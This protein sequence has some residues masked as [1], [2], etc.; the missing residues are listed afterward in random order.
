[1]VSVLINFT[2][3]VEEVFRCRKFGHSHGWLR[4]FKPLLWIWILLGICTV[5]FLRPFAADAREAPQCSGI[6]STPQQLTIECRPGYATDFDRVIIYTPYELDPAKDWSKQ[7]DYSFATWIFDA[8][9][10]N[11]ANLIIVFARQDKEAIAQVYDDVNG[12]GMI[13]YSVDGN[14]VKVDEGAPTVVVRAQN[15][16]LLPNGSVNFNFDMSIDGSVATMIDAGIY[17]DKL[18]TDGDIDTVIHVRDTDTDGHPD[19]EWR[20]AYPP[21]PESSGYYR[22]SVMV[23]NADDESPISG[24]LWWSLLGSGAPNFIKEDY[25]STTKPPINSGAAPVASR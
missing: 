3:Q 6:L 24:S 17:L 2:S 13:S 16:W 22:S 20:Q 21:L 15:D 12:D 9:A 8:G 10:D 4:Y 1:M 14:H 19:Y 5:M 11:R 7:L 18:K 25:A 23:N